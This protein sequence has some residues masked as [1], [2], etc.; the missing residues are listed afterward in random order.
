LD[1][2]DGS[3]HALRLAGP[4]D[5]RRSAVGMIRSGR[6]GPSGGHPRS[7]EAHRRRCT[8]C[9]GGDRH[10]PFAQSGPQFISP[11]RC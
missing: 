6:L 7:G 5:Q 9:T 11:P 3:Q 8:R 1:Q 4:H 10:R 2:A